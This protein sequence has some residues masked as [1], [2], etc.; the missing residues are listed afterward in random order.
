[1]CD[2]QQK[3]TNVFGR[4]RYFHDGRAPAAVDFIPQST[5]ADIMWCVL[6]P[7]ALVARRFGGRMVT[8]VHDSYLVAVPSVAVDQSAAEIK[9]AMERRFDC[10]RPG[11]FIPVEIKV[12]SPGA[13]W[14]AVKDYELVEVA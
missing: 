8:Q 4:V 2:T 10:I 7:V 13:S 9:S 11:F 3:V 14:N 1:L 12:A 5:V 6:K